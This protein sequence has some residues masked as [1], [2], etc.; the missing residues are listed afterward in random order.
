MV[1]VYGSQTFVAV[2][3]SRGVEHSSDGQSTGAR[4]VHAWSSDYRSDSHGP[5]SRDGASS[6]A[7]SDKGLIRLGRYVYSKLFKT[8]YG[9]N[10][11]RVRNR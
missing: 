5:N 7:R 2:V 1:G 3:V 8:V 11:L 6:C 4:V 10:K 9:R